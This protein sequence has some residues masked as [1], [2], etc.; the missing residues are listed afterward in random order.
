MEAGLTYRML[1]KWKRDWWKEWC[2][3]GNGSDKRMLLK[4]KREW[5][6]ECCWNGSEI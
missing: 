6:K 4:W 5:L 3:S 1:L 2:W